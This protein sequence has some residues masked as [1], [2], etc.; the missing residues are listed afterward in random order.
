MGCMIVEISTFTVTLAFGL[1]TFARKGTLPRAATPAQNATTTAPP[2]P[3][4]VQV[5]VPTETPAPGKTG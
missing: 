5:P 2:V 1:T 4:P 3:I